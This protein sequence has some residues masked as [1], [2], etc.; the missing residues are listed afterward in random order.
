MDRSSQQGSLGFWNLLDP[1][2]GSVLSR[3][4]HLSSGGWLHLPLRVVLWMGR[5][6]MEGPWHSISPQVADTQRC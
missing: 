2:P 5:D 1:H 3:F 4:P 6:C